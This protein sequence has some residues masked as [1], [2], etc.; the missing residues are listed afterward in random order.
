MKAV[1][2]TPKQAGSG[3]VEE[4]PYVAPRGDDHLII[5]HESLGRVEAVTDCVTSLA[6]GDWVVAMLRRPDPVQA[7]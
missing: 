6:P 5:G 2:V 1:V 4:V 3:P 7:E